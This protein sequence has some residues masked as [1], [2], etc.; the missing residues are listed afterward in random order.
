MIK[1]DIRAAIEDEKEKEIVITLKFAKDD[2]VVA[3]KK[4]VEMSPTPG[5]IDVMV[6]EINEEDNTIMIDMLTLGNF[7]SQISTIEKIEAEKV[8]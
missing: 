3:I 1:N 6:D 4:I 5:D 2:F 8:V 7:V